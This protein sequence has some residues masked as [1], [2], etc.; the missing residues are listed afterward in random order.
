[1]ESDSGIM[2]VTM[3]ARMVFD[4]LKPEMDGKLNGRLNQFTSVFCFRKTFGEK[5]SSSPSTRQIHGSLR[6]SGIQPNGQSIKT[7]GAIQI[8]ERCHGIRNRPQKLLDSV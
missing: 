5:G 1:M 8:K 4:K 7:I 6:L 2:A 3:I